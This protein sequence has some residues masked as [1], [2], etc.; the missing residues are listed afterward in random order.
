MNKVDILFETLMKTRREKDLAREKYRKAESAL[1]AAH[2]EVTAASRAYT[3]ALN[4]I[5]LR[6][7]QPE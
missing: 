2:D 4:D 1:E 7:Q 6:A 5:E 3:N